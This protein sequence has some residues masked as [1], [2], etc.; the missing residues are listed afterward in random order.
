MKH[1]AQLSPRGALYVQVTSSRL[2]RSRQNTENL[3][4]HNRVKVVAEA[5]ISR[6]RAVNQIPAQSR[7]C[8][9]VQS[10]IADPT[11][12]LHSINSPVSGYEPLGSQAISVG[13][14]THGFSAAYETWRR[15]RAWPAK[16]LFQRIDTEGNMSREKVNDFESGLGSVCL[17]VLIGAAI[18]GAFLATQTFVT[19]YSVVAERYVHFQMPG[20]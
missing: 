4:S 5:I 9:T 20:R 10:L 6:L 13:A 12:A 2:G 7:R 19:Q 17:I 8:T 3:R 16:C 14:P 18:L 1:A 15:E 11:H